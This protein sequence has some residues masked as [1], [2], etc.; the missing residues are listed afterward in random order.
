MD[1]IRILLSRC[2]ALFRRRKLDADL[3]EEL[4]AHIDLA[5][6]ENLQRGMSAQDARSAALRAFGGLTQT[7]EFYR[8]QRGLP[9]LEQFSRDLQFAYRQLRRAPG[10]AGSARSEPRS[11]YNAHRPQPRNLPRYI[12]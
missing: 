1:W 6:A 10:F 7:C 12:A 4:R 3:D 11:G 5:V 9:F 8:I 2:A